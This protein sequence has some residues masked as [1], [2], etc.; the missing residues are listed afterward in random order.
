MGTPVTERMMAYLSAF[1]ASLGINS[2]IS[3]PGTFVAMGLNSPRIS[4]GAFGFKSN[5][6]R[7]EGPPDR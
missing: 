4:E 2:Q 5:M 3:I 7:C 6:S 1:L